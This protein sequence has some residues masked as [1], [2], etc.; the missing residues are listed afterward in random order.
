MIQTGEYRDTKGKKVMDVDGLDAVMK[1]I[2]FR[3]RDVAANTRFISENMRDVDIVKR[4]ESEIAEQWSDGIRNKDVA[5]S[6]EARERLKRWNAENPDMP[7]KITF[8][9]VLRRV[10]QASLTRDERFMK[11]APPELRRR[12]LAE[13]VQ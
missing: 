7:I 1:M 11:T 4:V 5:E 6:T 9:Q 13:S 10:R 12:L 3:P 8:A 2:G